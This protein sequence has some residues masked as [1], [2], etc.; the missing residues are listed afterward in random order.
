MLYYYDIVNYILYYLL[1]IPQKL[2]SECALPKQDD[3]CWLT[4]Q[5]VTYLDDKS[6][7][8]RTHIFNG[9]EDN[10]HVSLLADPSECSNLNEGCT[11]CQVHRD[12]ENARLSESPFPIIGAFVPECTE[13]GHFQT[14][15]RSGSSGY[16]FCYDKNGNKVESSD[17]PPG[18]P[19]LDCSI[20]V[21]KD[22]NRKIFDINFHRSVILY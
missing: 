2:H 17:T 12:S 1:L 22:G 16:S 19:G 6:G 21:D 7:E 20:H 11:P 10:G 18:P 5:K 9:C 13:N 3:N 15:Q 8:C 4:G 14:K